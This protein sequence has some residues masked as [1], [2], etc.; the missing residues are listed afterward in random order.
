M[1]EKQCFE[2][3]EYL[4]SLTNTNTHAEFEDLSDNLISLVESKNKQITELEAKLAAAV[5]TF[6]KI[7]KIR[8]RDGNDNEYEGSE[9]WISRSFLNDLEAEDGK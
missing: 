7:S 2:R 4:I 6:K 3:Y 5:E 8:R 9:V 1:N